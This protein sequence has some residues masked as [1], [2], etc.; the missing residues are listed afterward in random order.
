[1]SKPLVFFIIFVVI[2]ISSSVKRHNL[3]EQSKKRDLTTEEIDSLSGR[4]G[5]HKEVL[6]NYKMREWLK[7]ENTPSSV[8]TTSP[9]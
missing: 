2:V 6:K 3:V 7:N 5:D 9:Q 8:K 1:M 4:A